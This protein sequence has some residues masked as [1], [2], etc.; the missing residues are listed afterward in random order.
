MGIE[1]RTPIPTA[2]GWKPAYMLAAGDTVY[3]YDG[4]PAKVVSVQVYE[5]PECYKIWFQDHLTMIVDWRTGIPVMSH[6]QIDN[7]RQ[8]Q[9]KRRQTKQW[10]I[11]PL[12]PR[13][14]VNADKH[15][16]LLNCTPPKMPN[17]ELPVEPYYLGRW[18]MDVSM[19]RRMSQF[20]IT[21]NLLEKYP[22]IPLYIP[23]EYLFA[24]FFQRLDL[25][26][27]IMS[28]RKEPFKA[29]KGFFVVR[30]KDFRLFRQVQ[31]LVE[32]L[33]IR[34][35][36]VLRTKSNDFELMFRTILKLIP[37]QPPQK[38]VFR[39]E[40]RRIERVEATTPRKCVHVQTDAP[41][42]TIVISEGY[43]SVSL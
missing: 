40:F 26:R 38:S 2:T 13:I 28:T 10:E 32:S 6:A 11:H 5:A 33:G 42:N 9:R 37:D 29:K 8:W 7:Y 3:S 18:V 14:L 22:V 27:G 23:D 35:I 31:C 15:H 39:H 36:T 1:S 20:H 24:S 12:G 30:I 25:L 34:G 17:R 19:R 43:L 4:K 41:D 16:W 21:R